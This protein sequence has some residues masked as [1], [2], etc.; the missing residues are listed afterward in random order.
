MER[1]IFL[2]P[3]VLFWPIINK[4][5]LDLDYRFSFLDKKGKNC[6]RKIIFKEKKNKKILVCFFLNSV[7]WKKKIVFLRIRVIQFFGKKKDLLYR[8][9]SLNSGMVFK[10]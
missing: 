7:F 2:F 1:K 10:K 8:I 5:S 9:S 6:V 3:K 4:K